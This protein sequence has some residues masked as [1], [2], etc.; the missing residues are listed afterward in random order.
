MLAYCEL[1]VD[2]SPDDP[3]IRDSR[4]LALA[5][6]GK[7][8][9]AIADFRYYVDHSKDEKRVE[10]RQSWIKDL[11]AGKNPFTPEVLEAIKDQ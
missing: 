11:Q 5:L 4:G 9:E 2:L 7:F 6:N 3:N 1:A 10:Q 8:V